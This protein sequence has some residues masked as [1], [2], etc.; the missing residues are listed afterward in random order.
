MNSH[1]LY[2]DE[3]RSN[4]L[5]WSYL[6]NDDE[7]PLCV[8]CIKQLERIEGEI[9]EL[10]GRPFDEQS[11]AF[12]QGS[13]CYDCVRWESDP[14]WQQILTKNRSLFRYNTFLKQLIARYKY[15]G[16]TLLATIFAQPL[17]ELYKKEYSKTAEVVA[18]PLSEQRLRERGF[19]QAEILAQWLKKPLPILKATE[20]KEKQ[21]KKG[22]LE[23]IATNETRFFLDRNLQEKIQTVDIIIIDDIYTTG[24]TIRQAA[25][26][27]LQHGARNVSSITIAR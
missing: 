18:I 17:R 12:Q 20:L 22:R 1:C 7:L 25:K 8:K 3:K 19:N 11:E 5:S 2:C 4:Q 24:T 14:N 26:L 6:W 23:R 21:S 15:R 16:D 9:C 10:C 27:L 13:L